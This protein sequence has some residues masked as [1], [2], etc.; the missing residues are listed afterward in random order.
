[1][2]VVQ[3]PSHGFTRLPRRA[4]TAPDLVVGVDL[5]Y[6]DRVQVRMHGP[7]LP[8][9]GSEHRVVLHRNPAEIQ[10][11]ATR[12]RHV[13]KREFV[14]VQ[15]VD[16]WGRPAPGRPERP[17]ATLL[18][19]S[20]EPEDELRPCMEELAAQGSYL[21]FD[22]LLG[23]GPRNGG[24]DGPLGTFREIFIQVLSGDQPL[25][26]RFDSELFLPWPML[27]LPGTAPTGTES[28]DTLFR[29]FLGH[30]HQIEQTCGSYPGVQGR[31]APRP[32]VI[33]A[34][35]LN[36]DTTIDPQ[37]RTRA[38][39]VAAALAKDTEFTERTTRAELLRALAEGPLDEQLMYFWCHGKFRTEDD[40]TPCLVVRLTD[41]REID[42]Y[43]VRGRPPVNGTADLFRPLVM[44]N[45]CYAGLPSGADLAYLG[46]AL[47]DRGARGVIG[48]QIEMPQ[49]FAAE[50]ALAFL[51]RYL[52]GRET[53]GEIAHSL[54]RGFA[55]RYRNP[56][57]LA[58]ALHGGMDERLE[59][60]S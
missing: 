49:V 5:M 35:S 39:E 22:L 56:L 57:G 24:A 10:A 41:G 7:A 38:G 18:D 15:S 6:G 27:A 50:Y 55:D 59:R 11:V 1:M 36:H 19:L 53:A 31:S 47:I 3:D 13:W 32:P 9:L 16:A 52:E 17:Y 37:K 44:L 33:P 54:A 20:G 2:R 40:Q 48:P 26:V 25:R 60:A 42:A 45:A 46:R 23:E 4:S 8:D 21:L 51:T 14:D 58:Y 29:R 28:L 12:L 43:T 34:V 30:R